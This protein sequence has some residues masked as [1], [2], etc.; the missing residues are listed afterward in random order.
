MPMARGLPSVPRC[1]S[2]DE[3]F[4]ASPF[5]GCE[6]LSPLS[7]RVDSPCKDRSLQLD[8]RVQTALLTTSCCLPS[9]FSPHTGSFWQVMVAYAHIQIEAIVPGF[10]R[11]VVFFF[12]PVLH[13]VQLYQLEKGIRHAVGP[14]SQSSFKKDG[15]RV[16]SATQPTRAHPFSP[17]LPFVLTLPTAKLTGPG[18]AGGREPVRSYAPARE[19]APRRASPPSSLTLAWQPG[20]PR[21][22]RPLEH[23]VPRVGTET[24]PFL[25]TGF[26]T[27]AEAGN[28]APWEPLPASGPT[29]DTQISAD[30]SQADEQN[31]ISNRS[32]GPAPRGVRPELG[33]RPAPRRYRGCCPPPLQVSAPLPPGEAE[34]VVRGVADKEENQIHHFLNFHF[35]YMV[36]LLWACPAA[37]AHRFAPLSKALTVK[38]Q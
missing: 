30:K 18:C 12:F 22:Q 14:H 16:V 15:A 1:P 28:R 27:P 8:G 13:D 3:C 34:R 9:A 36:L 37:C 31:S 7:Q 25:L 35:D 21:G 10:H 11:Q 4:P 33:P 32:A 24:G 29:T 17:L 23:T 26:P 2:S 5:R 6:T 20:A 19:L 38:S